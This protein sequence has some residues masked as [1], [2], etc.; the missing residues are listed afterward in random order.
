MAFELPALPYE[1]N[2]LEATH[3]LLKRLSI[4]MASITTNVCR[5]AQRFL[6]EGSEFAGKST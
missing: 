2:A 6:V 3:Y 4:I 1:K 5:Q